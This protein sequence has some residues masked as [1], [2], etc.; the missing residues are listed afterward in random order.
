RNQTVD[1]L[2]LERGVGLELD[3]HPAGAARASGTCSAAAASP[4]TSRT[5][6]SCTARG[7]T[8]TASTGTSGG[9]AGARA[10]RLRAG[11]ARTAGARAARTGTAAPAEHVRRF[12][13]SAAVRHD[14][15]HRLGF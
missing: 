9:T 10:A 3:A 4:W 12:V 5:S 1:Q 15:D 11:A 7:H 13:R 14:N 8:G 6:G 2:A